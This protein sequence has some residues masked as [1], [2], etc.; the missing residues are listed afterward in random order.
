MIVSWLSFICFVIAAFVH[1]GFFVFE[2]FFLPK[3]EIY[4]PLG[5]TD[6]TI[7]PVKIWA[8][9]VAIYNLALA[10]GVFY[11]LHFIFKKQIMT[12]GAVTGLC[13][14][15]M[16]AA[17]ITLWVTAP[18]MRKWALWQALPPIVGFFFLMLHVLERVGVL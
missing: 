6:E 11:G 1:I 8:R 5:Y 13:G 12:A 4:R 9:N 16:I 14:F 2:F 18:Q 15:T 17:G 7:K 10:V 3:A